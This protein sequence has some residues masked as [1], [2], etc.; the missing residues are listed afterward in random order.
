VDPRAFL[1][2]YDEKENENMSP[3]NMH[4]EQQEYPLWGN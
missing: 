2:L 4:Q 3:D 1:E